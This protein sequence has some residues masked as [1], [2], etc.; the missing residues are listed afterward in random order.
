MNRT[1]Q[2]NCKT[3]QL[4]FHKNTIVFAPVE[5]HKA[6][7]KDKG[8]KSQYKTIDPHGFLFEGDYDTQKWVEKDC[9]QKV[10]GI[11]KK[12]QT[13]HN[14]ICLTKMPLLSYITSY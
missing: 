11:G 9:N 8:I 12:N 2:E 6:D 7:V 1:Y 14:E 5:Y 13:R 4:C 3:S 10:D